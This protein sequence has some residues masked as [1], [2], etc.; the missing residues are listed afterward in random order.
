MPDNDDYQYIRKTYPEYLS[1][2]VA[3]LSYPHSAQEEEE[4]EASLRTCTC[5]RT[6][7]T[8]QGLLHRLHTFE[9]AHQFALEDF[10][11]SLIRHLAGIIENAVRTKTLGSTTALSGLKRHRKKYAGNALWP[12]DTSQL[13]PHG[14]EQSIK[15]YAEAFRRCPLDRFHDGL[16]LVT[17]LLGICG[18]VIIPPL[19]QALP[20]FP[21]RISGLANAL[22]RE[23]VAT[24]GALID[25]DVELSWACTLVIIMDFCRTLMALG[26]WNPTDI[27]LFVRVSAPYQGTKMSIG[28]LWACHNIL[29]HLPLF[30]EG[31]TYFTDYYFNELVMTFAR[32][33]AAFYPHRLPEDTTAYHDAILVV[34][35][36]VTEKFEDPLT[37]VWE[38]L[39]WM[40]MIRRCCAPECPETFVT[41]QRT[42]ARCA[43]CGI[44]RYCSRECQKLAWK[45]GTF[46]HKDVCAK[47][48]MLR[49]RKNLP[50]DQAL[51]KN[52]RMPFIN[53]C[54][55]DVELTA[56]AQECW[57]HLQDMMKAR[58]QSVP[59]AFKA[60]ETKL[61]S[62]AEPA[63]K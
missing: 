35:K 52:L 47:L 9:V 14:L 57:G 16:L 54:K 12:V 31:T 19:L 38:G 20:E 7:G 46:P 5:S 32:Y 60:F 22:C 4:L 26:Q 21:L 48:R 34:H 36:D 25:F 43:G 1:A 45:H 24:R 59:E 50:K 39:V 3:F 41:A 37:A 58:V 11:Q 10:V 13:I 56:L 30:Q 40:S 61:A 62:R 8:S 53:A 23:R 33:G 51:T 18:R 15:G 17:Q 49:D 28:L 29:N 55:A 6:R 2:C 63:Q 27:A 42:F 44:P